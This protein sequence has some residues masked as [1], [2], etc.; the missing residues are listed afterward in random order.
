MAGLVPAINDLLLKSC[1]DVDARHKAG[2]DGELRE[3]EKFSAYRAAAAFAESN[4]RL[5]ASASATLR[6]FARQA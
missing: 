1:K 4:G 6:P 3:R 5:A 2:H